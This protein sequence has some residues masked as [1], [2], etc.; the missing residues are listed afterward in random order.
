MSLLNDEQQRELGFDIA[1]S[2]LEDFLIDFYSDE[3]AVITSP[4][5]LK[6]MAEQITERSAI[7]DADK[8]HR[9]IGYIQG[10]AI[11]LS[12]T[13]LDIEKER[14]SNLRENLLT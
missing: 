4:E 11:A 14:V 2:I 1:I 3:F 13:S 9:W 10:V 12:F 5:Y 7:W 8:M 6:W